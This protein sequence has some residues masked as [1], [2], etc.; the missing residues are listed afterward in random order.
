MAALLWSSQWPVGSPS[1]YFS[2]IK[3]SWIARQRW[4][5]ISFCPR[6][7]HEP[8]RFDFA[9]CRLPFLVVFATRGAGFALLRVVASA[10]PDEA[11]TRQK[12]AANRITKRLEFLTAASTDP[13][14]ESEKTGP[15]TSVASSIIS[16]LDARRH[17]GVH[18]GNVT[19]V[20]RPGR[21]FRRSGHVPAVPERRH[22]A[23]S[24]GLLALCGNR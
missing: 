4:S 23:R 12:M 20:Y 3:A 15:N 14:L 22:P 2:R 11:A 7:F 9:R 8:R 5:S 16:R 10:N 19:E 21:W 17:S 24:S 18:L 13:H 6:F 1:R